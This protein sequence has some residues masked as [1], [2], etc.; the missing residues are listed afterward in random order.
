MT[1][2]A[3]GSARARLVDLAWACAIALASLA[4]FLVTL[5]R[6]KVVGWFDT[7]RFYEPTRSLVEE[8]LRAGRLPLWNPH[9]GA[10][11]P[12][13][14]QGLHGVLH[15]WSLLAAA[16]FPGMGAD[17]IIL[18]HVA[19]GAIG[20]AV[21]ARALGASRPAGM[22]AGVAYGLSGFVLSMAGNLVFLAGAGSAPWAIA[23]I[24]AAGRGIGFLVTAALATAVLHLAGDPQ[25]TLSAMVLGSLL[26][27]CL[28]GWRRVGY[29]IL[30]AAVGTAVAAIQLV[31]SW[32]YLQLSA[33]SGGLPDADRL[34]WALAPARILE[35]LAP[36]FF[37]GLPGALDAPAFR[38]LGGPT[39]YAVPFAQSVS[40]GAPTL[41]LAVAGARRSRAGAVLAMAAAGFLW[42]A[43]GHHLGAAA[44]LRDVPVLG[45]L[46]YAEK[47]VG[48]L[49]LCVA[50]LAGL[51]ADRLPQGAGRV[52]AIRPIVIAGASALA[53]AAV[54]GSVAGGA[55]VRG[56]GDDGALAARQLTIGLV[57]AGLSLTALAAW[58]A[59][60]GRWRIHVATAVSGIA[61]LI[62]V[63]GW[64]A[65]PL[66]VHPG[67]PAARLPSP[68]GRLRNVE[69][70]PRILTPFD[71]GAILVPPPFD[72]QDGAVWYLS[73][74]GATSFNV[75]S[76]IDQVNTYS[77]MEPAGVRATFA[78]LLPLREG[79]LV[80]LRRFGVTHVVVPGA[81]T[82]DSRVREAAIH[83]GQRVA[84]D[85]AS[86]LEVWEVPHR[87]WAVFA[88]SA[89][90]ARDQAEAVAQV[91]ALERDGREDVVI[92]GPSLG[93]PSPGR[94]LSVAREPERVRVEAEAAGPGLLVVNDAHWPGWT[95]DVDGT[96]TP[97]LEADGLVRAVRWPA[98]RHVLTMRYE[99]GEVGS[100]GWI[101][102]AGSVVLVVLGASALVKARR[103]GG[104]PGSAI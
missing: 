101:T 64:A 87:P 95:A 12:L 35:F 91:A 99:P 71:Q 59:A 17:P 74:M 79:Q 81:G 98:G 39:R 34:Q 53:L 57:H 15:P 69:P 67:E 76:R 14:A 52:S 43:L 44:I 63:Q 38:L 8:A 49:T 77:G 90:P 13:L 22:V 100:G 89:R 51:G 4:P 70:L 102:V 9:E 32:A 1:E 85:R 103:K 10:G 3:S 25:W 68:L 72:G 88:R 92:I 54:S 42:L 31:P 58:L 21:L 11:M 26:A 6:G 86:G 28:G 66:A 62:A 29:G 45:S 78:G 56:L 84:V 2:P 82:G 93:E 20:A 16:A 30:A 97:I 33:R 65:A 48:P 19:S 50:L 75:A 83:G 37:G 40:I 5:A 47:W 7:T 24:A 23:G 55:L 27:W 80:A 41:A 104:A 18:L 60:A 96:P 36:G 46:R 61:A 94:V 73:R